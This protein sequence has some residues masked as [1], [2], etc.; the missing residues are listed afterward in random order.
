MRNSAHR[1]TGGFSLVELL[2][3]VAIILI[4]LSLLMPFLGQIKERGRMV[5]CLGN[6]KQFGTGILT[7]AADHDGTL[8]ATIS[9]GSYQGSEPW[10]KGWMGKEALPPGMASPRGWYDVY[11]VLNDY[12]SAE[13]LKKRVF[14]CPSLPQGVLGSGV[15]SNG[16]HDYGMHAAFSGAKVSLLP[17]SATVARPDGKVLNVPAPIYSEEEP[18][19]GLNDSF[20]DPDHTSINREGSWHASFSSNYFATDGSSHTVPWGASPGPQVYSW[21]ARAPSGNVVSLGNVYGWAAW[22]RQ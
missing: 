7:F 19:Y 21:L 6:L 14:R 11:G 15:G 5:T 16:I 2:A 20:I 13:T 1:R 10:Q 4:L 12:L 9:T 8:T 22:N 17:T 18:A 3:V